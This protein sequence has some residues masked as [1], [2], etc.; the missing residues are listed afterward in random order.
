LARKKPEV[1]PRQRLLVFFGY[2]LGIA[3]KVS[4]FKF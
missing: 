2:Y 4:F 1:I 3:E